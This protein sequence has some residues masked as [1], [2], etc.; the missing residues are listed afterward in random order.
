MVEF[1]LAFA[2]RQATDV[3]PVP[4]GFAVRHTDFHTS[5]NNNRLLATEATDPAAVLDAADSV[6]T[7]LE[8]RLIT[9]YDDAAGTE[10]APSALAAGYHHTPLLAMAYTGDTPPVPA[11]SVESVDVTTLVPSLR[12]TWQLVLPDSPQYRIDQLAQRV[13]ARLHGADDVLFLAVVDEDRQVLAR[14]DLYIQDGLAQIEFVDTP[15]EHRGRGYARAVVQEALRRAQ[16]A[17]CGLLL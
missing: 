12:R 2:R 11:V 3:V 10:F 1:E 7:D 6:L 9:V 13:T 16:A 17:R 15:P 5:H 8:H 14:V 4:G